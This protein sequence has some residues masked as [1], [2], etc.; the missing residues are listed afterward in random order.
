MT[1]HLDM[2]TS[3]G[4]LDEEQ[5]AEELLAER[6]EADLFSAGV[7]GTVDGG[8]GT[9]FG[10]VIPTLDT[11]DE[12][13]EWVQDRVDEGAYL[14]KLVLEDGSLFGQQIPTLDDATLRAAIDEAASKGLLSVTHVSTIDSATTAISN[15]S[16]GL[17]H[18]FVDTTADSSFVDL[19]VD[20]D[21]FV[22]PTLVV[23]SSG[24]NSPSGQSVIDDPE[25]GSRL[26]SLET[27]NLAR[28]RSLPGGR[29]RLEVVLE[30]ITK[31]HA[32]GVPILAGSD[33]P[34]P[35]TTIG[36]SLHHELEYFTKAGMSTVEALAA[37]TSVPAEIFSLTDRGQIAP[38]L[39]ADLVLVLVT[40]RPTSPPPARSPPS[41]R[42]ASPSLEPRSRLRVSFPSVSDEK[43]TDRS[44]S[45]SLLAGGS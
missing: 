4:Y 15:G 38:G 9:Q 1:T 5:T 37:A 44:E 6:P 17:A 33:A 31:L 42:T 22:V 14:I 21:A 23:I 34:N 41:G 39:L 26:T 18:L 25:L 8:Y 20:N 11:A 10:L 40:P 35:G 13:P 28:S 43:D 2:F 27:S 12:A 16:D 45:A 30:S 24:S 3:P 36:A 29:L 19:M 7:L 32:A